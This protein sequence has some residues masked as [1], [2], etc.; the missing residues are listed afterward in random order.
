[1][2]TSVGSPMNMGTRECEKMYGTANDRPSLAQTGTTKDGI[3]K[4][5][6][7]PRNPSWYNCS[8]AALSH[9]SG[10]MKV[11]ATVIFVYIAPN[12]QSCHIKYTGDWYKGTRTGVKTITSSNRPKSKGM[13]PTKRVRASVAFAA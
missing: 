1:M 2:V 12:A 13:T 4:L 9:Q 8:T 7:R 10:P 5:R 3:R 6:L 11:R